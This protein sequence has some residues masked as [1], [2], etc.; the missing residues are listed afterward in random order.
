MTNSNN[1]LWEIPHYYVEDVFISTAEQ[2]IDW[3]LLLLK[4]PD[5]W[6]ITKGKN[7]KVAV[8]D[9]GIDENNFNFKDAIKDAKDFTNSNFGYIDVCGHGTFSASLVGSRS[10]LIGIAPECKLLVAKVLNDFGIGSTSSIINGIKW[11][12]DKKADI[13]SMSFGT[14]KDCSEIKE[15]VNTLEE[16]NIYC[17]ASAGNEGPTL[18]TINYPARYNNVVSVGA[19]DKDLSV[20]GFSSRGPRVDIAAPG[21]NITGV[22]LNNRLCI[23]SGTSFACPFVSGVT[24]LYL[25]HK[26]LSQQDGKNI[27]E[28]IQELHHTAINP[29]TIVKPDNDMGWGVINPLR[30]LNLNTDNNNDTIAKT[31]DEKDKQGWNI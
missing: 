5:I 17:I 4:V 1:I 16:N 22:Y 18:D 11:A 30:L 12:I 2:V 23:L 6:K 26:N 3:G 13:V 21:V 8:L 29:N 27:R 19:I 9:T 14:L 31:K 15:V 24:A 10:S 7:I 20:P 25:A 28:Y